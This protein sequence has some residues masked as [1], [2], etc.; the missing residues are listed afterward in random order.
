MIRG[1]LIDLDGTLLDT[2]GDLAAAANRMLATLRLPPRSRA[3][4]STYVGKGIAR[5]VERCLTGDLERRADPELLARAIELFSRAYDEESGLHSS[6]YPGVVEGLDALAG[7]GLRLACVTNKAQRF[8]LPL[9]ERMGLAR[10]FE[11]V[12]CGDMVA[13]GKPD[14]LAYLHACE[15]LALQ[16]QEAMVVGDSENDVIAA[17]AA[18]IDVVCVAYGY[19]EGKPVES[20][21]ADAVI[22]DLLALPE[23]LRRKARALD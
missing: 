2:A 1:V 22:T 3:E 23:L 16:P 4:V 19:T 21:G 15:R 9:L 18:G 6:V 17:R 14:P 8:T 5:L 11:A 20:L 12:V 10:R 13:R 7:M